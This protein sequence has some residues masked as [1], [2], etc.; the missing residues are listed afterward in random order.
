LPTIMWWN[1]LPKFVIPRGW[2]SIFSIHSL[3]DQPASISLTGRS[4]HPVPL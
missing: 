4:W 1:F 3:T 2:P